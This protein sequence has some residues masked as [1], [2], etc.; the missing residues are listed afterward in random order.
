MSE[1]KDF[2]LD[3]FDAIEAIEKNTC[4]GKDKFDSD[5]LIQV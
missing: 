4:L 2:L 5:E 1:D 3:I